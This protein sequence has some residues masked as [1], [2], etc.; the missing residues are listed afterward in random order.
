[1]EHMTPSCRVFYSAHYYP[2]GG[3]GG[4]DGSKTGSSGQ[5]LE[6]GWGVKGN[7]DSGIRTQVDIHMEF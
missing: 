7:D 6:F 5:V 3:G 2:K 4:T 1:M